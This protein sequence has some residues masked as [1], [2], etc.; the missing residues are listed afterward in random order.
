MRIDA[1]AMQVPVVAGHPNRIPFEGVLTT[2]DEPS[3]RPPSGA[4]GHRVV[5]AAK[6]ARE[7]LPSL[8]GMAIGFTPTYDGHDVRRKCGLITEADVVGRELR[9]AGY[10]YGRDF[11]EVVKQLETGRPGTMGMSL[12][13][14]GRA[15]GRHAGRCVD[16]NAGDVYRGGGA[17][18]G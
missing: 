3:T 14:G 7:A 2:V 17:A 1:M 6:A 11:P 16:G 15:G 18:A 9:V 12:R 5:L 4:K 10:V 13:V 8:L